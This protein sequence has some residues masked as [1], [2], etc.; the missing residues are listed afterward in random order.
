[1]TVAFKK[2]IWNEER[3]AEIGR[4]DNAS[5]GL[6]RAK[7]PKIAEEKRANLENQRETSADPG[8]ANLLTG[9]KRYPKRAGGEDSGVN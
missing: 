7:G 3:N 5:D 2:R 1:V 9:K 4:K 8:V 6:I